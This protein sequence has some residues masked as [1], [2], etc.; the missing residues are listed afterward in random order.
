M[1]TCGHNQYY[2]TNCTDIFITYLLEVTNGK[3]ECYELLYI[4]KPSTSDD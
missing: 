2:S 1:G 4:N 3:A